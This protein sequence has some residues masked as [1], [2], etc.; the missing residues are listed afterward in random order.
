[1]SELEQ[2][3]RSFREAEIYKRQGLLR[4]SKEKFQELLKFI[5]ESPRFSKNQKLIETV[6]S[7]VQEVNESI[8]EFDDTP[9]APE[10]DQNVQDLIKKLFSFSKT[11][12][13]AAIE[14]AVALA[15]FGQYERALVEFQNLLSQ[16][17]MP[18]ISAKNIIRCYMALNAPDAAVAQFKKWISTSL[19]SNDELSSVRGFLQLALQKEGLEKKLPELK[20][21]TAPIKQKKKQEPLLLD[22]SGITIRFEYGPLKGQAVDFDVD[23]QSANT[24]SIVISV[25]QK[26]LAEVLNPGTRLPG[27]QCYS[28]ITVFR[29][30][31]VVAGKAAIKQGPRKGD[32]MV[33]IAIE[34]E[35]D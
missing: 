13:A 17:I 2:I 4:E 25:S 8:A 7:K 35:E 28:P 10:L 24:V 9:V 19:I 12:E 22:I 11:E 5:E 33:D 32:Y 31:G 30:N 29:S 18:G 21:S 6:N 34:A 20:K 15:K 27:M 23:F 1:M 26:E 14:G 16:G 3:K